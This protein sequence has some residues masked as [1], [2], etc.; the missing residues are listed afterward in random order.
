[1]IENLSFTFL[2]Q[3][4]I[5]LFHKSNFIAM[6]PPKS[7]LLDSC[8]VN[9]Q[10]T[11]FW[12]FFLQC[13]VSNFNGTRLHQKICIKKSKENILVKVNCLNLQTQEH[14]LKYFHQLTSYQKRCKFFLIK[15]TSKKVSRNN[16][17]FLTIEITSKKVR[18][19]K[20]DFSISEIISK[21]Y[22]EIRWIFR[23][24]KLD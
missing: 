21:K 17:D 22:V 23:L 24:A 6:S 10:K 9:T 1:M 14:V 4:F 11:N 8:S 13:Q 15:I 3:R 5:T 19:N 12:Q 16:V 7:Y 18:R 2:Y 20:M